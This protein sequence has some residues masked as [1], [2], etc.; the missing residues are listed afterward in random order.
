MKTKKLLLVLAAITL[1]FAITIVGCDDDSTNDDSTDN[2]T[3]KVKYESID[4]NGNTY[5][6]TITG[7]TSR[8]AYKGAKGDDY[9]LTIKQSGQPDKESKGVVSTIGA[10]GV[11]SLKPTKADDMFDVKVSSGKM[12]AITGTITLED[13]EEVPAPETLMPIDG[14]FTSVASMA[15]WLRAQPANTVD[16]PYTV[17]V[18]VN[19]SGNLWLR[20]AFTSPTKYIRLDLSASTITNIPMWGDEGAG[21]G[22]SNITGV[23]IPTSVTSINSYAFR[24]FINLTSIIIPD[25]VTSIGWWSF[26]GS[27]LTSVTI[28]NSVTSIGEGAFA[29]CGS[30]TVIDVTPGNTAYSSEDGVLYNEDKTILVQYPGGKTGAFTIP[31]NVTTIGKNAFDLCASLT[32]VTIPAGVT[33]IGQYAFYNCS[34]L[35]SVTIGSGVTSIGESAFYECTSLTS[36]IIPDSVTSI[37]EFAF[38]KC[39]NL[40]SVTFQG[41]ITGDY[42]SSYTFPGNL[43]NR[44]LGGG[45]GTYTTTAPVNDS[46]V[47]TKQ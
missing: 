35:T 44:Y 46:S 20:D 11:L 12:T 45:I 31:D 41:A 39:T 22:Y 6:L 40:T 5:I 23:I 17:K 15:S 42:F 4:A 8:A 37:G 47:W 24:G 19:N 43:R 36:V 30:L 2:G 38:W 18:N 10:D 28:P 3:Q 21:L 1:L 32:D 26:P 25:S 7:K 13:G 9:V 14:I 34:S 16:T 27:G 33:S 29:R